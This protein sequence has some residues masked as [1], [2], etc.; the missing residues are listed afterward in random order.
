MLLVFDIFS[1]QITC[2]YWSVIPSKL[3][4]LCYGDTNTNILVLVN[5][6]LNAEEFY[7]FFD[8]LSSLKGTHFY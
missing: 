8:M 5:A 3:G 2:H 6:I 1:F 7:S 4:T